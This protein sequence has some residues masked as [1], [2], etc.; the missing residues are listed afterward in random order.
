MKKRIRIPE[1]KPNHIIGGIQIYIQEKVAPMKIIQNKKTGALLM[2][3]ETFN[4]FSK[5]WQ[6]EGLGK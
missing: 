4:H 5:L 6:Q 1:L 2:N 3:Q